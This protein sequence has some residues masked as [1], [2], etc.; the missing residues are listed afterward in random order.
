MIHGDLHFDN[1]IYKEGKIYLLDFER[2]HVAPIDY[3]FSILNRCKRKPWLWANEETDMLT[4]EED[5]QNIMPIVIENYEELRTIPYLKDRLTFYELIE[6]LKEYNKE[7][8]QEQLEIV[9]QIIETLVD[10]I[11]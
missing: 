6:E 11:P 7:K 8:K 9:E 5:Y 10:K 4:I 2:S 3:D 1:I